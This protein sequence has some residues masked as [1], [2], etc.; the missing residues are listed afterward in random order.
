MQHSELHSF[1]V[2]LIVTMLLGSCSSNSTNDGG[3]EYNVQISLET[4]STFMPDNLHLFIDKHHSITS[5]TLTLNKNRTVKFTSSTAGT[6]ELLLTDNYGYEV[7]RFYA[8]AGS[9]IDLTI[10]GKADSIS[11]DYTSATDTINGWLQHFSGITDNPTNPAETARKIQ[12]TLDSLRNCGETGL[13][14]TLLL[15]DFMPYMND[16]IYVRRYIGS[17]SQSGKPEWL[18]KSIDMLYPKLRPAKELGRL[19]ASQ[20]QTHDTLVAINTA[21]RS[22]YLLLY[23][24]GDISAQSIDSLK[25]LSHRVQKQYSDRRLTFISFCVS[26]PDSAWWNRHIEDLPTGHHTLLNGGF[27]DPRITDWSINQVPYVIVTDMFTNIQNRN[28]WNS[29]LEKVLDRV[30]KRSFTTTKATAK[31]KPK[32]KKL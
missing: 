13:R 6:D 10:R 15:R 28:I 12:D 14:T 25:A 1:L 30:P 4:D 16:S 2:L 3:I 22:D 27:S 8:T 23:F 19:T 26:A 32:L 20:F 7:C 5:D 11:I 24:W 29:D 9:N 18:I 17:I 21:S 31:A